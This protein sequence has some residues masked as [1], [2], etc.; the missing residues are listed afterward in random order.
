VETASS[1]CQYGTKISGWN[2]GPFIFT[3]LWAIFHD[4]WILAILSIIPGIG[5]IIGIILGIKGNEW[6]WQKD[7][8]KNY[9]IFIEQRD[10]WNK[11]GLMFVVIVCLIFFGSLLLCGYIFYDVE[12]GKTYAK[13]NN[14]INNSEKMRK[15][16]GQPIKIDSFVNFS[17]RMKD[18]NTSNSYEFSASGSERRG[19][20]ILKRKGEDITYL[21]ITLDDTKQAVVIIDKLL[22]KNVTQLN[23]TNTDKFE[24]NLYYAEKGDPNAQYNIANM[25]KKGCGVAINYTEALIWYQKAAE[26]GV[27]MAQLDL[28]EMYH[29]GLGVAK[30]YQKAAEWYQKAAN[31]G[32]AIA[33]YNLGVM[34][35][36]GR[37]LVMNHKQAAEWYQKASNQEYSLA[38]YN[39][40]ILYTDG[41]GVARDYLKA[42]ELFQRA[43]EKEFAP[44][45]NA[46]GNMYRYGLGVAKDYKKALEWYQKAAE[47]GNADAQYN[48]GVMYSNGRGLVMD[49]KKAAEWYKKAADQGSSLAQ[50][51]L[52][53]LYIDGL[54]VARDY[55]KA[56]EL[57]QRAAEKEFAPAQNALGNMY[58]HS[59]GVSKDYKKAIFWY[60]KAAKQNF[61]D[62]QSKLE[63]LKSKM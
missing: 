10:R 46:L 53:I 40:A 2:W 18:E 17:L 59:L 24:Q 26:Q 14:V 30:N 19:W 48:L 41:L 20:I 42:I 38:E 61:K 57:F 37:G 28:A 32:S 12:Y 33:Q 22:Y 51:N 23:T 63:I 1:T 55:L 25:Y 21:S 60:Q 52:A 47:Q 34:Y 3:F 6:A 36:N 7:K 56:I 4:F 27:V 62:A 50:H 16:L 43:A 35:S 31:Q 9:H 54:G 44:A 45:Q 49:H 15:L 11:I 8:H 13:L 39:L 58:L 5:F 29:D